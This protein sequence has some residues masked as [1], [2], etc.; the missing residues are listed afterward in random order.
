MGFSA[1]AIIAG[2]LEMV[3]RFI[4]GLILAPKI[5]YL[6]AAIANPLAWIFADAFLIPAFFYCK[7]R[8]KKIYG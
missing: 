6:A 5:G 2:F 3:A 8:L 7:R 1:F 4:A